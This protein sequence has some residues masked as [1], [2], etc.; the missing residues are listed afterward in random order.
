MKELV[1][2][3]TTTYNYLKEN[4]DEDKIRKG[5]KMCTIKET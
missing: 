1:A 3:R 4:S 2:L 5:P